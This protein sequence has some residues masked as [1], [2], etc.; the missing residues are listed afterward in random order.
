MVHYRHPLN[1]RIHPQR[2]VERGKEI[3][4]QQRYPVSINEGNALLASPAGLGI[5]QTYRF[6]AQPHLDSGELVSLLHDWQPPP[7]QMYVVYPSTATSAA[8]CG[9]L[10]T[11]RWRR[12]ASGRMSRTL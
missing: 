1:D 6:M 7:E 4:I 12:F 5:I 8:N 10:S 2:Y 9:R 11:G 3:A